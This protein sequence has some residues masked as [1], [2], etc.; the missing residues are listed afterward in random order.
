MH[1]L[2]NVKIIKVWPEDDYTHNHKKTRAKCPICLKWVKGANHV[3]TMKTLPVLWRHI[4]QEHPDLSKEK[5]SE[6]K[7]VMKG[8]S[9]A[10]NWGMILTWPK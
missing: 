3:P 9:Q 2:T 1:K 7:Q 10:L 5:L 6:I 4:R 8:L